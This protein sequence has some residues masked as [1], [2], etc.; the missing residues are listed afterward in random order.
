MAVPAP[1]EPEEGR[2]KAEIRRENER[3]ASIAHAVEKVKE[4]TGIP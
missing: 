2:S 1:A 4:R 3:K